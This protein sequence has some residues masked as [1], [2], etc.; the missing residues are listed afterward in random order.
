VTPD[1]IIKGTFLC[2]ADPRCG[3]D[4]LGPGGTVPGAISAQYPVIV[5]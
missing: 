3:T 1:K 4:G 5:N 2:P